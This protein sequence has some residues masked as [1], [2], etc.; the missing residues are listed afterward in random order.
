MGS[1]R[2]PVPEIRCMPGRIPLR[3]PGFQPGPGGKALKA[4]TCAARV[5]EPRQVREEA[6][7]R[8]QPGGAAAIL[9]GAGSPGTAGGAAIDEGCAVTLPVQTALDVPNPLPQVPLAEL[10]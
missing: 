1:W 2:F 5:S 8:R 6:A 10:R 4:G 3:G 7:V 9:A